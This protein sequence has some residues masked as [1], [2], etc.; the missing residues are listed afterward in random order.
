MHWLPS[1]KGIWLISLTLKSFI[2]QMYIHYTTQTNK[3]TNKQ[4]F[5]WIVLPLLAKA[6]YEFCKNWQNNLKNNLAIFH[7]GTQ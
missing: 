7:F 3:Q 5:L 2:Y 4:S 6:L 1:Q